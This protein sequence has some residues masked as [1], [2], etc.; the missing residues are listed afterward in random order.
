[1]RLGYGLLVLSFTGLCG[2]VAIPQQDQPTAEKVFKNIVSFKGDKASDVIPAM[3]FMSASLKVDCDYCHTA[4]RASD[5]KGE[6]KTARD[7]IAM[8]RDINKQNFGGRNQITC[9]TCHAGHT[10]PVNLPPVEG[11][12][13]RPR[14]SQTVK[15]EEVLAAYGKAVGADATHT[16][17]GLQLKGTQESKGVKT[18]FEATYAGGK[19]AFIVKDKKAD[20]KQGFNGSMAWFTT[21]SGIQPV[22]LVFA[23]QFVNQKTIYMGPDTLPKLSN[24]SGGTAKLG[25]ND[26]LVVSGQLPDKTRVALYFDKK[27]GLLSRTM[28]SYPSILGSMAKINDFSD[29][30]SV[31]GV[32][33]PMTITYHATEGD[34]TLHIRSANSDDK[35]DATVFDPPKN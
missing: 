17:P 33:L 6:K 8:Q 18:A 16:I 32:K 1:M 25:K 27:S 10:H 15:P 14:R 31:N 12:E 22:P 19:Y 13:V 24:P 23:I 35:I 11:L 7:M 5:S 29:Y 4:D 28:F 20:Q 9:A 30:R 34:T 3:E 2:A 21:P 26:A